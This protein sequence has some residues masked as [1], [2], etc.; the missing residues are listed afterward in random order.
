MN[1]SEKRPDRYFRISAGWPHVVLFASSG[2][3]TND[4]AEHYCFL[5]AGHHV[6]LATDRTSVQEAVSA[7]FDV[8]PI[9]GIPPSVHDEK[10]FDAI[11]NVGR[12]IAQA[13][14]T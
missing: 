11:G 6:Y 14:T 2:A 9:A 8:E 10:P 4:D 7:Q 3:L 12:Y 13:R 1:S 5:R